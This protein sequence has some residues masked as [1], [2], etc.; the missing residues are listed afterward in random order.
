M[1]S[2][3]AV[4]PFALSTFRDHLAFTLENRERLISIKPREHFELGGRHRIALFA[5]FGPPFD[6]EIHS[7]A[8]IGKRHMGD[9]FCWTI[10][11]TRGGK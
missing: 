9:R 11:T 4:A 5:A 10:P 6:F 8:E 1:T 7:S 2:D 3:R